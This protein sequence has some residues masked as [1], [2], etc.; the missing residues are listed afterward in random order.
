MAGQRSYG[1]LTFVEYLVKFLAEQSAMEDDSLFDIVMLNCLSK[2]RVIGS[3]FFHVVRM[4]TSYDVEKHIFWVGRML[5]ILA[6]TGNEAV[7][8]MPQMHLSHPDEVD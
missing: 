5:V 3:S 8:S 1:K 2:C 7:V 6:N 4:N